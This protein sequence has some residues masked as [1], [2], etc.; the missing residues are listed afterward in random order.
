MEIFLSSLVTR[1]VV[2]CMFESLSARFLVCA[3]IAICLRV[4]RVFCVCEF[5]DLPICV[6]QGLGLVFVLVCALVCVHALM[7]ALVCA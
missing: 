1:C 2:T 6:D 7:C 4:L 5:Q 3:V